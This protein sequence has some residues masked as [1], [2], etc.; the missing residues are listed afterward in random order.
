MAQLGGEVNKKKNVRDINIETDKVG[1][2]R[3]GLASTAPRL[4][5]HELNRR[6]DLLD[7]LQR[8]ER[9]L[10]DVVSEGEHL[11]QHLDVFQTTT[12]ANK[13]LL[14]VSEAPRGGG[15][16]DQLLGR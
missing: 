14:K 15:A 11:R 5:G 10:R 8:K 9:S 4:T 1:K 7:S 2:L 3:E 13:V 12:N 16:R 6:R